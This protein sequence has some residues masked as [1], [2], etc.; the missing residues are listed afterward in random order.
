MP[1]GPLRHMGTAQ[2][3]QVD[4]LLGAKKSSEG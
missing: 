3:S 1:Q 2:I 4:A